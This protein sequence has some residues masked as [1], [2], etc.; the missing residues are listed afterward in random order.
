M[1]E[2]AANV[3][4]IRRELD[5]ASEAW[6]RAPELIAVSKFVEPERVNALCEAGVFHIGENHAQEIL[7]KLPTLDA[8]FKIDFT[9]LSSLN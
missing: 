4:R 2:I 7:K 5:E 1:T 8:R 6:G 9:A 3:A